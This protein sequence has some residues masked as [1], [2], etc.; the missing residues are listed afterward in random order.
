MVLGLSAH[1]CSTDGGRGVCFHSASKSGMIG[2][3]EHHFFFFVICLLRTG[4]LLGCAC[5]QQA[6]WAFF[7]LGLGFLWRI[8]ILG[9]EGEVSSCCHKSCSSVTPCSRRRKVRAFLALEC[10]A[11]DKACAIKVSF[12]Q[13]AKELIQHCDNFVHASKSQ[14]P[15]RA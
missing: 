6:F 11:G 9:H 12:L 5:S 8:Q 1:T 7:P 4:F 10:L 3:T 13:L 14:S 15:R 2:P